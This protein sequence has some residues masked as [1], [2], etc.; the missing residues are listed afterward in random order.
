MTFPQHLHPQNHAKERGKETTRE[1]T[2]FIQLAKGH[3]AKNKSHAEDHKAQNDALYLAEDED[4]KQ[5]CRK[6]MGA[7]YEEFIQDRDKFRNDE[8]D[9][10]LL[11]K[12]QR[13]NP[14]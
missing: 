5:E 1:L 3:L 11:E 14:L 7:I 4:Q 6:N 9:K 12:I 2:G 10:R 8:R 13:R